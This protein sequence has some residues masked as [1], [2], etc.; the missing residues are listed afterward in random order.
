ML[1]RNTCL[2]IQNTVNISGPKH[3]IKITD[4][5]DCTSTN[6]INC[7]TRKLCKML[8]IGETGRRQGDRFRENLRDVKNNDKGASKPVS[9]HFNLPGHSF[10]NMPFI[11]ATLKAA[12]IQN[13]NLSLKSA[14]LLPTGSTNA[15]HSTNLFVHPPL[16]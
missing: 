9:K 15:Y 6:V 1:A 13:K 2:F 11:K 3:S 4:R 5:F 16:L 10:N 12:K 7:I 8:Y 14:P